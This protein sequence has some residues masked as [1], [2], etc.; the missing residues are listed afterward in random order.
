MDNNNCNK[1]IFT[2]AGK[3]KQFALKSINN[4]LTQL[5]L[6][7]ELSDKELYDIIKI[8][9]SNY[10]NIISSKKWWRIFF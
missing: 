9:S 7:F 8:I 3:K 6:H 4:Y 10:K 1:K 2:N 5:Q